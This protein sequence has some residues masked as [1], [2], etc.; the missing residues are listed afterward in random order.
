MEVEALSVAQIFRL[1]FPA[2]H[3]LFAD[4]LQSDE[5]V[6]SYRGRL[7]FVYPDGA[8]V[9]VEKPTNRPLRT[10]ED[11]WYALFEGKG[12][13]DYDDLGMFDLG[14][15]LQDLGYVVL[16]GGRDFRSG[17][18]YLI[19]IAPRNRPGDYAEV[20][21]LRDV[22]LPYAIYHGLLRASQLYRMSGR[23]VEYVVAEVEP[24]PA[25]SLAVPVF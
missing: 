4:R 23:E 11:A 17:T 14:E 12:L 10:L 1:L 5:A 24:L 20:L 2:Q 9:R 16:A 8:V 19:R 3:F 22:T 25:E 13:C 15:I 21:R 6:L 18:G 7:V